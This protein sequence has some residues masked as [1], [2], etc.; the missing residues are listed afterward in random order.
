MVPCPDP[1]DIKEG[2]WD[3][4]VVTSIH[5]SKGRGQKQPPGDQEG[6]GLRAEVE[7]KG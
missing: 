1:Q 3:S 5:I 2:D 7:I 6:R 4:E